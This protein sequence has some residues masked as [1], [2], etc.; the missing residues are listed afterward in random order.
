MPLH[1]AA[2]GSKCSGVRYEVLIFYFK[3]SPVFYL[4]LRA[5]VSVIFTRLG[6]MEVISPKTVDIR[7]PFNEGIPR[8]RFGLFIATRFICCR[9]Q[10]KSEC[11]DLGVI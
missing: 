8:A 6:A 11:L 10:V 4:A 5:A 3:H 2:K 7:N 1:M 9:C